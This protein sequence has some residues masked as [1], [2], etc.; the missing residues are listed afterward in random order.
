MRLEQEAAP[1]GAGK[2]PSPRLVGET[3]RLIAESGV[4]RIL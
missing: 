1:A 2:R 4:S 3:P